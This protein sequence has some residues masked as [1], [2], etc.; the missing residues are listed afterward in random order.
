MNLNLYKIDNHIIVNIILIILVFYL[1]WPITTIVYI[2]IIFSV[3]CVHTK[4]LH[5]MILLCIVT[6]KIFKVYF[7]MLEKVIGWAQSKNISEFGCL[8][9]TN[10]KFIFYMKYQ[11][12]Q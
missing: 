7:K 12:F 6:Y 2:F 3:I 8:S 9:K 11:N 10:S 4:Y 5:L 1:I